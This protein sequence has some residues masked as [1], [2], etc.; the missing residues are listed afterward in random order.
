MHALN[1]GLRKDRHGS[2]DP[3]YLQNACD[4]AEGGEGVEGG[5]GVGSTR[6]TSLKAFTGNA[7]RPR[8]WE[9]CCYWLFI[10]VITVPPKRCH[11]VTTHLF[12]ASRSLPLISEPRCEASGT[13]TNSDSLA[14]YVLS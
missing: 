6:V 14:H 8:A 7:L 13:V 5:K 3:P 4:K 11:A 12:L 10:V 1:H 2:N 9:S